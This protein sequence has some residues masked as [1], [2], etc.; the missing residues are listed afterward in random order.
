M[1]KEELNIQDKLI[2]EAEH[3]LKVF[4]DY[5]KNHLLS[6]N[7]IHNI[8]GDLEIYYDNTTNQAVIARPDHKPFKLEL[9]SILAGL[10]GMLSLP[11]QL[12]VNEL[13]CSE[14]RIQIIHKLPDSLTV[15]DCSSNKLV[16]ILELPENLTTLDCASNNLKTLPKLP[17]CLT[18][19]NCSFNQL[20]TLP[21]LPTSLTELNCSYNQLT[22][23]ELPPN[24]TNIDCSENEIE[25]V[26]IKD[27]GFND[28]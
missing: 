1:K 15:L 24:I 28:N 16:A 14:N 17:V 5:L 21:K 22:S 18:K 3:D 11:K 25:T 7:V 2:K 26:A 10:S 13:D 8:L 12:L 23:L 27:R 6:D 9:V 4:I 19:L 20:K